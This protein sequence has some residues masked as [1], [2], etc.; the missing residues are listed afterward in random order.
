LHSEL[1]PLQINKSRKEFLLNTIDRSDSVQVW[2]LGTFGGN[3]ALIKFLCNKGKRIILFEQKPQKDLIDSWESLNEYHNSIDVYWSCD[4]PK[5]NHDKLLFI[6]PAIRPNH[7][8][9]NNI[10]TDLIST[11]IELSL[12]YLHQK[13]QL[14]HVIIGS[15][16][17][18]TC[19]S[20]L[21][22]ALGTKVYG[23]IG[24]SFLNDLTKL[25]NHCVAEISSFQLHYLKKIALIPTSFLCTPIKDNHANWHGNL[26]EYQDTKLK[27]LSYWKEQKSTGIDMNCD[28]LDTKNKL[29]LKLIGSHNS[30]NAY[31]A[32]NLLS[33]LNLYTLNALKK[34][35]EFEGLEHRFEIVAHDKINNVRFINDSKATSPEA[36]LCAIESIVNGSVLILQGKPLETCE[37]K[38]KER[39]SAKGLSLILISGMQMLFNND[40]TSITIRRYS[41]LEEAFQKE[42]WNKY[43]NCDIILSPSGPSYDQYLNYQDRGKDFKSLV[44][45]II[46]T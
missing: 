4:K 43:T 19:A 37:T 25:P 13:K 23:N 14:L 20:L 7:P 9:L 22:S 33:K 2:G 18:S 10:S 44:K 3:I 8:V 40:M 12:I 30:L 26:K 15:V 16:G 24:R 35:E 42:T 45:Q 46:T 17:K 41:S 38:L 6:T 39:I 28:Q 36:T 34:I 29:S 27:P 11:E 21:A 32:I 1:N 31:A 5:I